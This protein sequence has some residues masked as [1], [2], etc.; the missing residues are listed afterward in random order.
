M[1]PLITFFSSHLCF[2]SL[3]D[4]W[5]CH[6][7]HNCHLWTGWDL[8]RVFSKSHPKA[9]CQR[10][11]LAWLSLYHHAR[12][13]LGEGLWISQSYWCWW[14]IY[15]TARI[16]KPFTI[17]T[18]FQSQFLS[19]FTIPIAIYVSATNSRLAFPIRW[20][21]RKGSTNLAIAVSIAMENFVT[22]SKWLDYEDLTTKILLL[23]Y[24][25]GVLSDKSSNV[26]YAMADFRLLATGENINRLLISLAMT[27]YSLPG[28]LKI[29]FR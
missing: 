3:R 18:F 6:L 23:N 11:V 12:D 10:W 28:G 1:S 15:L 13:F 2:C 20:V 19:C 29:P 17:V 16:S 14:T 9:G 5:E 7:H 26:E 4:R 27:A 25:R 22:C 21:K 24:S 8:W